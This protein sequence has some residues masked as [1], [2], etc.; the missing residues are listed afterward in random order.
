MSQIFLIVIICYILIFFEKVVLNLYI[1]TGLGVD[2]LIRERKTKQK[3]Q[4]AT[5]RYVHYNA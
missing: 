3:D 4:K 2:W 1:T 5:S